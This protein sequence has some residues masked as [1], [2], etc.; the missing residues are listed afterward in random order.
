[1]NAAN[2]SD[3]DC[4]T[5]RLH[6]RRSRMAE[7]V[8]LDEFCRIRKLAE[9]GPALRSGTTPESTADFQR[10]GVEELIGEFSFCLQHLSGAEAGLV[11]W[12]QTRF[13]LEDFKLL[14]RGL[15]GRTPLN[16]MRP[17]LVSLPREL[18]FDADVLFKAETPA[19]FARR[20]P[21]GPPRER[22]QGLLK[23]RPDESR[24]FLL[25]AA[26]DAGYFS[27]LVVRTRRLRGGEK[28]FVAPVMRQEADTFLLQLAVRGKFHHGL[29][30]EE[31][32]PLHFPQTGISR[33]GFRDMLAAPDISAAAGFALGRALDEVPAG[34][35][36]VTLEAM[37]LRRFQRLAN[38]AFRRS[39]LGL[40][41]VI[42]YL[43][44]RR[45]ELANLITIS[46]GV[47]LGAPP[48]AI[49]A[50]LIPRAKLEPAYV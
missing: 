43:E 4:L 47:R 38:R 25:E 11:R 28:E 42:G 48:E 39:H 44:L 22:L 1:M 15:V 17:H 20:L 3:L 27:E 2:S 32:L 46:E 12:L 33:K 49:R 6:A 21:A 34:A 23:S 36:A 50:R 41:A 37:A 30:P 8:R 31:L 40:G 18:A 9:L 26:L 24:P 10:R 13:Q 14:L 35:G 16:I 29:A 7:A 45:V 5:A 19:E